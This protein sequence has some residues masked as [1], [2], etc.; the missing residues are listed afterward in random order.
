MEECAEGEEGN[1]GGGEGGEAEATALAAA[2]G[3]AGVHGAD[4]VIDGAGFDGPV[5]WGVGG[6]AAAIG[7]G[8]AHR[9]KRLLMPRRRNWVAQ[10][11][12]PRASWF[13]TVR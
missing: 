10:R 7:I 6:V 5:E 4:D 9:V 2:G 11:F 12:M 1:Y 3:D 8:G 13:S